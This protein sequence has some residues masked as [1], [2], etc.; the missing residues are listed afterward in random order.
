VS[1][2]P[3]SS[4][5]GG[6]AGGNVFVTN[7]PAD[8]LVHFTEPVTVDGTVS[9]DNLPADQLVHFTQPVTVDVDNFPATYP[10]TQQAEPWIVDGSGVTQPVSVD[11][12]PLPDGA[13]TEDTLSDVALT[14]I[15]QREK[16][17]TE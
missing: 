9:V 13:A 3:S 7:F 10:V 2:V 11:A 6:G 5:A 14:A 12:L 16:L 15:L 4:I 1:F 8:Q 17:A